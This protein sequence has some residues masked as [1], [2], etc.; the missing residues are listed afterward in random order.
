MGDGGDKVLAMAGVNIIK[1]KML[2]ALSVEYELVVNEEK[3]TERYGTVFVDKVVH[4]PTNG[5][6]VKY[7]D[8]ALG[9]DIYKNYMFKDDQL[10]SIKK[11]VDKDK[12]FE[13]LEVKSLS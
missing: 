13:I 5:E 6:F 3:I 4:Y 8:N 7:Y 9:C 12:K 1:R 2:S 10:V 11:P